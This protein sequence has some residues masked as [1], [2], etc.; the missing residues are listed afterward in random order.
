M[1]A[2]AMG[3]MGRGMGRCNSL[4][5]LSNSSITI[6]IYNYLLSHVPIY[7][8][9]VNKNNSEIKYLHWSDPNKI[10]K[11]FFHFLFLFDSSRDEQ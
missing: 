4:S 9:E 6:I 1:N 10:K 2:E 8:A 5:C 7:V 3:G 11:N